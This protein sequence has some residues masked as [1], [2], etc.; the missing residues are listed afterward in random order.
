MY[1]YLF[2]WACLRHCFDM[3]VR[4]QPIGSLHPLNGS[5]DGPQIVRFRCKNPRLSYQ[6]AILPA[7]WSLFFFKDRDLFVDQVGLE[8]S[9]ILL[10]L[11]PAALG[12]GLQVQ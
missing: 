3:E 9:V 12:P 2:V 5:G 8:I 4:T 1:V 11:P 10:P 6:G 7:L